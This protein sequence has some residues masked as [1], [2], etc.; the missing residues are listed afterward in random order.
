MRT[1][2]ML[3]EWDEKI[4]LLMNHFVSR[5]TLLIK[6]EV[7]TVLSD[8]ICVVPQW[9]A[10]K[11]MRIA[12]VRRHDVTS[13]S[14]YVVRV[15]FLCK[16]LKCPR[17]MT[18]YPE[19]TEDSTDFVLEFTGSVNED[20]TSIS[21]TKNINFVLYLCIYVGNLIDVILIL[22]SDTTKFFTSYRRAP[23]C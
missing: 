22:Y 10:V 5:S 14:I 7:R 21:S 13:E 11:L 16:S 15:A 8:R 1:A 17:A 6:Y 12:F 4:E 9:I 23:K 19:N 2:V 18:K 3:S 20:A